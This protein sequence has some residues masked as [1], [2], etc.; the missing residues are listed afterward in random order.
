MSNAIDLVGQ[1]FDHLVVLSLD[2]T[3]RKNNHSARFWKCKCDCGNEKVLRYDLLKY[4]P[5]RSCGHV[6]CHHKS[7]PHGKQSKVWKGYGDISAAYYRN[8]QSNAKTRNFDFGADVTLEYLWELFKKQEKKCALTGMALSFN[9]A[10]STNDG[11]ASLDRIDAK[12]GY[13]RGNVQW[14]HKDINRMKQHYS[15]SYFIE[16]CNKVSD[17]KGCKNKI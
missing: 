15:E 7:H 4:R 14:I 8:V 6:Q 3:E 16:M 12:L 13:V 10:D 5:H 17:Y 2:H 1:R 9:V 11:T